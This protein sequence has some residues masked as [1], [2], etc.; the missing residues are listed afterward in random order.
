[1]H[2]AAL[3]LALVAAAQAA[4]LPRADD[5]PVHLT[6]H[7]P[8]PRRAGL[9]ADGRH[10]AGRLAMYRRQQGETLDASLTNHME[11]RY[12][13]KVAI[14][15]PP[16][17][18]LLAFDT[19]S[20]GTWV[21]DSECT[22]SMCGSHSEGFDAAKSSTYTL[23]NRTGLRPGVQFVTTYCNGLWGWDTVG[24]G[25]SNVQSAEAYPFLRCTEGN[26]T[27]SL[28]EPPGVIGFSWPIRNYPEP[29]WHVLVKDWKDKRFGVYLAPQSVRAGQQLRPADP[30]GG[31]LTLGGVNRDL[32]TGEINY[33]PNVVLPRKSEPSEAQNHTFWAVRVD[34][35]AV[36]SST[37]TPGSVAVLD[38]GTP[39]S[40]VP[41][42]VWD[43]VYAGVQGMVLIPETSTHIFPCENAEHAR[44]LVLTLG[45]VPY[46]IPAAHMF[47]YFPGVTGAGVPGWTAGPSGRV[48]RAQLQATDPK[49]LGY[50][51]DWMFGDTIL[52]LLYQVYQYDPPA[53]GFALVANSAS[54]GANSTAP[55]S[56]SP[57]GGGIT[58]AANTV[59]GADSTTP[60]QPFPTPTRVSSGAGPR[61]VAPAAVILALAV[62]LLS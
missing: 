10:A 9:D 6:L 40:W 33:V 62:A 59:F 5:G 34:S 43:A 14:G 49:D 15:T 45:G 50:P 24:V 2:T 26:V 3:V 41:P 55:A 61:L 53:V 60:I 19:G 27:Q 52:R 56:A 17:D 48:C 58:G 7:A 38:T 11:S 54:S 44:P 31:V 36:D 20:P 47:L 42:T 39:L 23:N 4:L 37:F 57:G 13:V 30:N 18:F 51:F 16:Q 12:S 25:N 46:T 28:A 35:A 1:M 21:Y 8:E 32:Y 22:P 29:L